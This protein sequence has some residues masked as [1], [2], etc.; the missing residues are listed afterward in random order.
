M[1]KRGTSDG[2]R[3][4]LGALA[5]GGM[6]ALT[7][8]VPIWWVQLLALPALGLVFGLLRAA[9]V[10]LAYRV[11]LVF[12][13]AWLLPTTYWYYS[14]MSPLVAFA[15]SAGYAALL[16]NLF[17][18]A[19]LRPRWG[20]RG[21]AP[22]FIV[23]WCALLW[24]RL[25]LPVTEDWWIPYAGYSL[26]RNPSLVFLGS[27]GGEAVFEAIVL[28]TGALTA[29]AWASRGWRGGALAA[30]LSLSRRSVRATL[31]CGARRGPR[32]ARR[33]RCRC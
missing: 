30:V 27:L 23:A 1:L 16:A 28:G 9:P 31:R 6:L 11:G 22:V 32:P 25:H 33:S 21:V 17:R 29:W 26:W 24:V 4:Y 20:M 5:A 3:C 14:F 10:K 12:C 8:F 13:L 15:A 7:V 18:L 2:R 19:G